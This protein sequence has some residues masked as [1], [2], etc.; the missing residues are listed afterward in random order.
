MEAGDEVHDEREEGEGR[1][2]QG[3]RVEELYDQVEACVFPLIVEVR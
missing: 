1:G 3:V 2:Q